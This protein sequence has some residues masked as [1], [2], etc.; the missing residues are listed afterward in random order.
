[1][2]RLVWKLQK[3]L[4]YIK[5]ANFI[6]CTKPYEVATLQLVK[7]D[8]GIVLI[9]C[10]DQVGVKFYVCVCL[11]WSPDLQFVF[12]SVCGIS[13][14]AETAAKSKMKMIFY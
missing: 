5:K 3:N 13:E 4:S 1:M 2:T 6:Q 8:G 14:K 7:R 9:K 12:Y 11:Q 10:A